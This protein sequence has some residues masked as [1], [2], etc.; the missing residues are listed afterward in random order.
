MGKAESGICD[1]IICVFCNTLS[2]YKVYMHKQEASISCLH[3]SPLSPFCYSPLALESNL[4]N[5]MLS[6]IS[7]NFLGGCRLR[8]GLAVSSKESGGTELIEDVSGSAVSLGTGEGGSGSS[9]V[10]VEERFEF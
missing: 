9:N 10:M 4:L 3:R 8:C 5:V 1:D 2:V 7:A 6:P